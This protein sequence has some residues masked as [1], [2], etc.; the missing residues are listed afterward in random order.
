[1]KITIAFVFT[2]ATTLLLNIEAISNREISNYK[3]KKNSPP[4]NNGFWY[5]GKVPYE[6]SQQFGK[7]SFLKYELKYFS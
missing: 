4:C 3:E 7:P 5:Q 2:V 1:M 6:I